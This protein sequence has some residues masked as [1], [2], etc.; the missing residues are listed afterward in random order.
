MDE[1]EHFVVAQEPVY[2]DV[3]RELSAGRKRTHWMW[4][5]FPQ[6]RGLGRSATAERFALDS[7]D[8]ARRYLQH[9]LLGSRLRECARLALD[10]EGRT[11]Q[12]IFGYPDW[13][14]FRSSMTLFARCSPPGSVFRAALDKYFAGEE[15]AKTLEILGAGGDIID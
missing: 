7:L 13:M 14:K 6:M 5:I 3:V 11:A 10:I 2:A 1:F 9:P 8:A 4:F 12:E 15:D